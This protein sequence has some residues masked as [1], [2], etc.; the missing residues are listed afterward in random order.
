MDLVKSKIVGI[1]NQVMETFSVLAPSNVKKKFKELKQMSP[2]ELLMG[3]CR[4]LFFIMYHSVFGI[5]YTSRRIWVAMM[6]L[7]QGP[8]VEQVGSLLNTV[9]FPSTSSF[10]F[11]LTFGC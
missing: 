6:G 8:P 4:L 7:M 10:T 2:T 3:F 9:H 11:S 1:K 5:F